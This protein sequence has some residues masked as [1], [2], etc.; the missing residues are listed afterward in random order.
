[1]AVYKIKRL[2]EQSY[3]QFGLY[4]KVW[5]FFWKPIDRFNSSSESF[6]DHRIELYEKEQKKEFPRY[7][8]TGI[9][10]CGGW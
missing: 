9:D 1:M 7:H 6:V 8:Y 3:Y 10:D 5:G 4:K 2:G